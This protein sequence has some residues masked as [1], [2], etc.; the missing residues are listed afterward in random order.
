MTRTQGHGRDV[1]ARGVGGARH[2]GT[3]TR[4]RRW[5]QAAIVAL[6]VLLTAGPA[7]GHH[8]E[9]RFPAGGRALIQTHDRLRAQA[10]R[11][12]LRVYAPYR[13]GTPWHIVQ[14]RARAYWRALHPDVVREHRMRAHWPYPDWWVAYSSRVVSCESGHDPRAVSGDGRY[15]GLFQFDLPTWASVGGTGD[16]AA[17]SVIE[18][19][20]RGYVLWSLHGRGRWPV[21]GRLFG[22]PA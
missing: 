4:V 11:A 22:V 12:D 19:R 5:A 8:P 18:Q 20:H 9:P 2:R 7:A 13:A 14:R 1:G 10:V 16:P 17:A 15:R 6:A 21:C 3:R